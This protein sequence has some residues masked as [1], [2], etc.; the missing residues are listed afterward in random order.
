MRLE[1]ITWKQAQR[2]FE[3]H[4]TVVI[5]IGSIE[6]HGSHLALG[7]DFLVP[8]HIAQVIDQ[9]TDVLIAPA[10][11]Y[12]VADHHFGFPGTISLGYDG[13]K[14]VMERIVGC[15]YGYGARKFIFLNGHGG[16]DGALLDVSLELEDMGAVS[17]LVNWWQLA[18]ELNPQ[19]KGGHGGGEETAA[20]LAINPDWVHMEDYMPLTPVD[21]SEGLTV[22]GMKTVAFQGANVIVQRHF[23]SVTP[24]GWY[25]PDDPKDATVE[26]GKEMLEAVSQYI[27]EFI[28]EFQKVPLPGSPEQGE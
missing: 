8:S 12:G 27:V 15:L 23:Q 11:P 18:G 21:L 20:I 1:H 26:W 19:W 17:A 13:L 22:S 5:P 14:L 25:G 2:Y 28:R 3:E 7:T 9:Q 24:S 10:V 4:D 6:N 16:N